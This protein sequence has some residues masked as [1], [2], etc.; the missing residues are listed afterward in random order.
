MKRIYIDFDSTLFNTGLLKETILKQIVSVI[1]VNGD[2]ISSEDVLNKI[3]ELKKQNN[4]F[5]F[6]EL[7]LSILNDYGFGKDDLEK[8]LKEVLSKACD[9]Y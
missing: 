3:Y 4:G 5:G 2:I 6:S 8:I 9:F 1:N 7:C